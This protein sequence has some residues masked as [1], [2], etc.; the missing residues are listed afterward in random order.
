MQGVAVVEREELAPLERVDDVLSLRGDAVPCAIER[1]LVACLD[2]VVV[3]IERGLERT[4]WDMARR[5]QVID[6]VEGT[7]AARKVGGAGGT[8]Q[9][10]AARSASWSARSWSVGGAAVTQEHM[11]E[12]P[13]RAPT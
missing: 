11:R 9:T 6:L 5:H 4:P 12:R 10:A 13:R 2:A 3:P 8:G 1:G 7:P